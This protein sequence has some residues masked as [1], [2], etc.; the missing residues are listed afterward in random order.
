MSESLARTLLRYFAVLGIFGCAIWIYAEHCQVEPYV[1]FLGSIA[2]LIS[3]ILPT[4]NIALALRCVTTPSKKAF[5]VIEN[6][7][8][9]VAHDVHLQIQI[10]PNIAVQ[11]MNNNWSPY[12]A[13]AY[14][15]LFPIS[16]LGPGEQQF[17]P[18]QPGLDWPQDG[19]SFDLVIKW[20]RMP[21]GPQTERKRR[22]TYYGFTAQT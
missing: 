11:Y 5:W 2:G 19:H 18:M 12:D 22:M 3:V 21:N 1:A 6:L 16:T 17:L 13:D 15:T 20:R 10:V 8:D 14:K 9:A 4:G 7:G